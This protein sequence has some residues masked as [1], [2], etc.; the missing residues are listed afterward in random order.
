MQE[1]FKTA[2][3]EVTETPAEAVIAAPA[4]ADETKGLVTG[5]TDLPKA[6][7]IDT[8]DRLDVWEAENKRPFIQDYFNIRETSN[9]FPL[10]MQWKNIDKH[11]KAEMGRKEYENTKENYKKIITEIEDEIGTKEL[12]SHKRIQRI[13]N[14]IQVVQKMEALKEKK[15]LYAKTNG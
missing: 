4:E 14:Y 8:E 7:D 12:L 10:K 6:K 15:K 11:I 13:F 2:K 1:A 3:T 9:E 5:E